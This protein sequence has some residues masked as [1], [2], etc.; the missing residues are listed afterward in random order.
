MGYGMHAR[1]TVWPVQCRDVPTPVWAPKGEEG[2]T[3]S[4]HHAQIIR[5]WTRATTQGLACC[6]PMGR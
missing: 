3:C 6:I 4:A 1:R 5:R 2:V